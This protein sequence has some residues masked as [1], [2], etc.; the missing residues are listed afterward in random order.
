MQRLIDLVLS[1]L[2]YTA[3]L[4]YVDNL[5]VYA[6]SLDEHFVRLR[7]VLSQICQA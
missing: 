4:V 5:I 6:R 2:S 1:G 3:C 7:F